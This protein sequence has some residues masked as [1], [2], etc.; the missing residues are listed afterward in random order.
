MKFGRIMMIGAAA[1]FAAGC[2]SSATSSTT[3]TT[4]AK[5]SASTTAP[6][7]STTG[8]PGIQSLALT[9]TDLPTGWSVD[10]TSETHSDTCYSDPLTKV[11]ST[12]YTSVRFTQGGTTPVLAQELGVYANPTQAFTAITSTL[13]DCHAFTETVS[14]TSA[15]GT[16]GAMSFPTVGDQS[17]AYTANIQAEGVTLVQGFVVVRKGPYLTAV[18]L[19]DIGS[20]DT[21]S[22]QQF[23]TQALGKVPA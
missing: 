9:V 11:P 17:A 8:A 15:S 18:A 20:L 13:N 10:S 4:A 3:T 22:L 23:V 19:G 16:L 1:L 21:T 6:A 5:S 7:T 2:S 14:G 12:S